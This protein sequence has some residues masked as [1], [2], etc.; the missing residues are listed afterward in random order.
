MRTIELK[1]DHVKLIDQTLLPNKLE[2][3][4]CRSTEEVA[5]AIEEMKIRGAPA[6]GAAA[7]MGLA[8][9]AINSQS[10]K[11]QELL[12]ELEKAAERIRKTRPTAAN[13]FSALDRVL[14]VARENDEDIEKLRRAVI[15]EAQSIAD[16]D[17]N[18]NKRIGENGAELVNEGDTILTHCNAGALACVDYGTALGVVRSAH[19][20]G[21]INVIATETRPFCQGARLTTWELKRDDIPV[22]LI[23]DNMVGHQMNEGRIDLVVV[24]ADR[25][26]ANGDVANKIGTY[27]IAVLANRHNIPFYVAA[28]KSTIDPSTNSG[29]EIEIEQRDP[30]EVTTM[31]GEKLAPEGIEVLHPAFDVTPAE[32]VTRIITEKGVFRPSKVKSLFD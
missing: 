16:E 26:A 11:P 14:S 29:D 25:I 17:V 6:L 7:G 27:T 23:T 1:D 31:G 22:T 24:G 21:K 5:Q 12:S 20:Q 8:I 19:K 9:T 28:P 4:K 3:V 2:F 30:S 32:L 10:T 15:E 18:V 13:L